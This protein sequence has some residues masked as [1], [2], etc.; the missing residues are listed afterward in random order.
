MLARLL[1]VLGHALVF[2]AAFGVRQRD[3]LFAQQSFDGRTLDEIKLVLLSLFLLG[4]AVAVELEFLLVVSADVVFANGFDLLL[5]V[6]KLAKEGFGLGQNS[7]SVRSGVFR[8]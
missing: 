8:E 5:I 2:F 3:S 1:L 4:V 7:L 6:L